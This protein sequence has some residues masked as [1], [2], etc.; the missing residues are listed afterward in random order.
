MRIWLAISE[1]QNKLWSPSFDW[2]DTV[3]SKV[4]VYT[5]ITFRNFIPKTCIQW[6]LYLSFPDNS[7]SRIRCSIPMVPERILFKLWLP[8]LLFSRIHCLFFRP[9]TKTM[10]R[11]FTVFSL[12]SGPWK[13]TGKVIGIWR[14]VLDK[15][16]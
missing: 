2:E 16:M 13:Y 10:N 6:N 1:S 11:G 4:T 7:F 3:Q 9:P 8:H 12:S 5:F 14:T 15:S